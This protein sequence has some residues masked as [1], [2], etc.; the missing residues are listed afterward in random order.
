MATI[1]TN[2]TTFTIDNS[3]SSPVTVGNIVSFSGLDGEAADIDITTLSSTSKEFRQGLQ[4]WG[5]FSIEFIRDPDDAG[6]A[7][8]LDAKSNQDQRTCILTL[9]DVVTSN[10]FT[11]EAVVKSVSINGAGVDDVVRG[12]ANLKVTGDVTLSDSSP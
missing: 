7:E 11:F 9:N 1:L 12:T 6:Q 4:D 5:N 3:G 2:G 10:V 8:L